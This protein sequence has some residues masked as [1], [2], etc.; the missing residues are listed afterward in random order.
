MADF[1]QHGVVT[2]FHDFKTR[3]LEDIEAE[4]LRF[5]EQRPMALILPSLYSELERPA[6]QRIIEE[7]SEVPYLNQIVVGLDQADES[8]YRHALSYFGRLPQKTRVIWN[9]GPRM[10]RI[11]Q[12]LKERGLTPGEPGKGRNVWYMF[13]YVLGSGCAKT[14]ALHDCDITTYH[15]SL[16]AK[17]LYPLANPQFS[18]SFCKGYYARVARQSMHGRVFRL[19]VTPLLRAFSTVSQASSYLNF[20]D[21][22]R[23]ALAGEFALQKDVIE[24]IRIPGDWGL[25]MGILSE[26]HRN[27]STNRICQVDIADFY[28]HKH[29][30]V[31]ADDR[32]RGLSR[33][34]SDIARSLFR[35]LATQG[36]VFETERIRTLRATY[37]R[38][39]L[40][41]VE[42]Y[43]NDAVFNGLNYDLHSEIQAVELFADN[44]IRAGHEFL[45]SPSATH[46]MPSWRQ[47]TSAIPDIYEQFVEAVEQDQLQYCTRQGTLFPSQS[48]KRV[49]NR[50]QRHVAAIYGE[51]G[52]EDF[53]DR[54][55]HE[56]DLHELRE[57]PAS[58][59]NKWDQSDVIAITYG[60]SIVA[61]GEKP[62][63]TLRGFFDRR[64]RSTFTGVHLLPF[65][66]F[67]SDD[68]FAVIDFCQVD[69]RLG[70][71]TDIEQLA[72][73]Y[74]LMSDLV[75]NHCSSQ[76]VWADQFRQGIKPGSDYFI[77]P[78]DNW[79]LSQVVRPRSSNLLQP[80]ET[81][82]GERCA[83]CTFGPDQLDLDYS[84]PDVLMEMLQ[85]LRRY[86]QHGVELLRLDAV[87]YLWK[88]SGTPCIHHEKT[89][90]LIKLMRL[91]LELLSP[92][93]AI[94][95]ET[96]VPNR[97]NLSYFGNENE[98]HI[99]YNFSLPPLLI[100]TLVSG[101]CSH[102]KTW[103][104]SM[105]PAR[106]GRTYFNFI[107][108]H[109]G[110]GIRPTE[111]LLTARQL[112]EFLATMRQFGG[113]IS[114]RRMPDGQDVPYEVNISLFDALQGTI[115]AGTDEF[116]VPRFL[117]AH[118][119]MLGLEGI[120]G[121][122][123]HSLL[124]TPNDHEL[125]QATGRS[126]SVN[127]HR[128]D[129][130][131]IEQ[132]LDD[133]QT[134]AARV[135]RELKRQIQI[136]AKQEAFHPNAT[137]YTLHF[138]D[139]VFA[140]WRES[141]SRNQCI[142]ALHNISNTSRKIP[143]AE[144]NLIADELWGDLLTGTRYDDLSSMLE[145]APYQAVWISNQNVG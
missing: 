120:P 68:G 132:A 8:Q 112:D 63:Q 36:Q 109:D 141:P 102:L 15:R 26:M 100:H 118:T 61:S 78:D 5:S 11:Q 71:W 4:L 126:R 48:E 72:S 92:D 75:L 99:I 106:Q 73:S 2:T 25:E 69:Q 135:F 143:L 104:M 124:A 138:G 96:N 85:V 91:V 122:Y 77:V 23:Y 145:L 10:Q 70:S 110:I 43:R 22:F 45:D 50:V 84:N 140:F 117:C 7:L 127:R 18:Y 51:D 105:P 34:T 9:D 44:I 103:M 24:D 108:S 12:R 93:A 27:Y 64:L 86:V 54:L 79:D 137:Q 142:F 29:Q 125:V 59:T 116:Q 111:G 17:L 21:S 83:W 32:N 13:G 131:E 97:E 58:G 136:R 46:F 38:L 123:I 42:S 90:E 107:A 81:P 115:S 98:A 66:P 128:W 52:A 113:L 3:P 95:T 139:D 133:E 41:L 76:S 101:N 1:H 114:Q 87:A 57:S 39:A 53:V 121:I 89:H 31:S 55:F 65:F 56:L 129:L 67:S 134:P 33:M 6:L 82:Q 80:F 35:K 94:I 37:Y 119:I 130:E 16:P 60:D 88:E 19:F 144:L 49:K 47:V 62:L 40:D 74:R 20:L 30:S 28:D 14:V